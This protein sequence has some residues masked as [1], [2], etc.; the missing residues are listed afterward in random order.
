[1]PHPFFHFR[2][3]ESGMR[4]RLKQC[5]RLKPLAMLRVPAII[6][7]FAGPVFANDQ[8]TAPRSGNTQPARVSNAPSAEVTRD[9]EDVHASRLIGMQV[10]DRSGEQVGKIEDIV[11]DLSDERVRYAVI[12]TGGF[13]GIGEKHYTYPMSRFS[14]SA[15]ADG[16]L[17]LDVDAQSL[18]KAPVFYNDWPDFN[19]TL[20][21]AGI[22]GKTGSEKAKAGETDLRRVSE[23]LGIDVKSPSGVQVGELEDLL[24]DLRS[25]KAR[26]VV[27]FDPGNNAD[28]RRVA[29]LPNR[30]KIPRYS[31]D[32]VINMTRPELMRAP[33]VSDGET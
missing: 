30:L 29:V 17:V 2:L 9:A 22:D 7:A 4:L 12:A 31:D 1:M 20:Y 15:N 11:V 16:D 33:R 3:W 8:N 14:R 25:G 6:L 26:A 28:E 24:I 32:A 19:D 5:F 10:R 23:L 21:R 27:T 13:L 18:S